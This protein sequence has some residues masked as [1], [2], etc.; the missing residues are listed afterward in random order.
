MRFSAWPRTA[1]IGTPRRTRSSA[2]PPLQLPVTAEGIETEGQAGIL[3]GL[4]C[5][6]GQ[7]H[8]FARPA[9]AHS[10]V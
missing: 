10:F 9:P 8:H 7:G 3:A 1:C 2:W 6:Y 4:G 5:R